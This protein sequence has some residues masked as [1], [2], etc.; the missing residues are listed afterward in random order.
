MTEFCDALKKS[1]LAE[2]SK[3]SAELGQLRYRNSWLEVENSQYK[4]RI[5]NLTQQIDSR[6]FKAENS[7]TLTQE[8]YH[9]RLS[10]I[11]ARERKSAG[12]VLGP[13]TSLGYP[14]R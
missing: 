4:K 3:I 9:S 10:N 2:T 11:L 5:D 1:Q 8:D 12:G 13:K 14:S 7:T 6:P